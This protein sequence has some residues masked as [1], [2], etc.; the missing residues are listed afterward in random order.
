MDFEIP[1]LDLDMAQHI[2]DKFGEDLS[3]KLDNIPFDTIKEPSQKFSDMRDMYGAEPIGSTDVHDLIMA[4]K[5]LRIIKQ[6]NDSSFYSPVTL[7][8]SYK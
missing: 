8:L 3:I 7:D 1:K 6:S 4:L 5:R 2:L